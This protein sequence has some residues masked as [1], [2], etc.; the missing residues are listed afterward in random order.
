MNPTTH[1]KTRRLIG[2]LAAL[3]LGAACLAVP[4]HGRAAGSGLYYAIGGG[5]P[6]SASAGYGY[7]PAGLGLGIN[8]GFGSACGGFSPF[9]TVKNQLNGATAG[10]QNMMG[11]VINAAKGAVASLPAMII[12]HAAPGLYDLLSNGVLQGRL[13]FN[14]A[15]L[16]CKAMVKRASDAMASSGW[17]E[18]AQAENWKRTARSTGD[19]VAAQNTVEAEAGNEGA[20]WVGGDK[21]GGTGQEPIRVTHDTAIA[22][23][24]LLLGRSD[25]TD[26]AP[27][28]GGNGGWGSVTTAS[29]P[30][31][32]AGSG[33]AGPGG[34]CNGGMC[35]V[36]G[37]PDEAADWI[38]DVV[39]ER[40]IRTCSGCEKMESSAGFGLVRKLEQQQ[41]RIQ[42]KLTALVAGSL[43][44]TPGNL[45]AVSAGPTLAISPDVIEALRKD[46]Q[47]QLLAHRLAAEIALARTLTQAIWARRVLL[48][49]ASE[50]GIASNKN[51]Q[52]VIDSKL[53]HLDRGIDALRTELQVRQALADN[54]AAV[55][56][57]RQ[58]ARTAVNQPSSTRPGERII[59]SRERIK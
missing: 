46:P 54:A 29:G 17:F 26:T 21:Y 14:K 4:S 44:V 3:L 15:K 23:Y 41:Q 58:R 39:G 20:T 28:P 59:D 19:A 16:S 37:S 34:A 47:G 30:W 12:Q 9:V 13:D 49:G 24:N 48:A 22:G 33:A 57:A 51:G 45:R 11:S 52:K 1:R 10:F 56:L 5:T 40:V 50:P 36:W 8:W 53:T 55:V 38:A 27:V 7:H 18:Q 31:A 6:V 35:T 32:G 43:P 25:P 42:T 2:L